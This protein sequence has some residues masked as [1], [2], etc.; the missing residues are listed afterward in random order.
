MNN[1]V[2]TWNCLPRI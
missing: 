2:H 1:Y